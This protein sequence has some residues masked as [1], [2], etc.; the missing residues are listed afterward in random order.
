MNILTIVGHYSPFYPSELDV[1]SLG[2]R[3]G[4]SSGGWCK[5]RRLPLGRGRCA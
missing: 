1:S 3:Q 4:S 5:Y 2:C